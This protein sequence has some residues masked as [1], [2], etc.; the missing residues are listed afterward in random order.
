[1]IQL[2]KLKRE[3]VPLS[4]ASM[5]SLIWPLFSPGSDSKSRGEAK[6]SSPVVLSRTNFPAS[7]PLMILYVTTLLGGRSISTA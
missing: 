7:L 5:T 2:T 3:G 4:L 6:V 1:M